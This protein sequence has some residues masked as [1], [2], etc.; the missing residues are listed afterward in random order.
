M[1]RGAGTLV[2][3]QVMVTVAVS[4]HF[5]TREDEHDCPVGRRV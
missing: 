1:G 2:T 5:P 3:G 4:Q